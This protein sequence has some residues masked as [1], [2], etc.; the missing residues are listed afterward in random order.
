MAARRG[1]SRE[2]TQR[3]D[4]QKSLGLSIGLV[5]PSHLRRRSRHKSNHRRSIVAVAVAAI[6]A[7][8][9]FAGSAFAESNG[10]IR[11][12]VIDPL[13]GPAARIGKENLEGMNF[14]L[15]EYGGK[16]AGRKIE[17]VMADDQNNPNVGLTEARRLVERE[18]VVA[19]IGNLNSAVALAIHPYTTRAKMPY[20]TG[21][22]AAAITSTRKSAYT[23]RSS[24]AAGQLEAAAAAFLV[25]KGYKTGVLMGSDYAAGHDAVAAVSRNLKLL[26]GSVRP[27]C[28]RARAKPTT[29]RSSRGWRGR[30]PT[31]ST[32]I[33]SAATRFAS[34]ASTRASGSSFR[35]S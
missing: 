20:I 29:R 26:G 15:D 9:L 34:C 8:L 10:P 28:F 7:P 25:R 3:R 31:S 16:V 35:W 13:S 19:I 21:G 1:L 14:A 33:S 30:R 17:F 11:I 6:G 2:A 12:G 4:A 24:F 22:I 32:A 18:K 27:S 23:F 5:T